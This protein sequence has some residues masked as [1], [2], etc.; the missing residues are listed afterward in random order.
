MKPKSCI[1]NLNLSNVMPT[2]KMKKQPFIIYHLSFITCLLLGCKDRHRN[3]ESDNFAA[4]PTAARV[5]PE[6]ELDELSGLADSQKQPGLLWTH[7]DANSPNLLYLLNRQGQLTGRV[8]MPV[9]N[10]DWE[11]IAIGPGPTKDETYLYVAD[12]GDNGSS[13]DVKVIYRLPEPRTP[14]ESVQN[15]E[16]I[17]FQY[18]DGRFD[19]ET[20]LLDPLTRDIFVVTKRLDKANV[21]RL[22]YPQNTKDIVTAELAT[23]LTI[24]GDLT[25]GSISTSGTEIIVR[26]YTTINYW[27]RKPEETV[28]EVLKR[29][30]T[31]ALPYLF[32]PQG[33]AVCFDK[34]G[35]GYFTVS[36]RRNVPFVNLYFYERQ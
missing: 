19:A 23:T 2:K 20:V 34:D 29:A 1:C 27:K 30:P 33:E 11:D 9:S 15:V 3:T 14:N 6:N 26:G 10:F 28:A 8:N 4:A 22:A 32:E 36:E 35:K 21:Y 13:R 18:P 5:T 24:G 7:G 17:R 25:G 12:I 16:S 31:K